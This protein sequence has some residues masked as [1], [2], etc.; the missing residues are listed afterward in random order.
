ML[1]ALKTLT[2]ANLFRRKPSTSLALVPVKKKVDP[3]DSTFYIRHTLTSWAAQVAYYPI[4][5]AE[6][7]KMDRLVRKLNRELWWRRYEP[8]YYADDINI[9]DI[10]LKHADVSPVV[11]LCLGLDP[12]ALT[13]EKQQL[14]YLFAV[15]Q[16]G[17]LRPIGDDGNFTADPISQ[18]ELQA[19]LAEVPLLIK[20]LRSDASDK[21][22]HTQLEQLLFLSG[23]V[24]LKR[25]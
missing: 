9:V 7:K 5:K 25:C 16:T 10:L 3:S 17:H 15:G 18:L 22:A 1:N 11:E 19:R 12:E 21:Y 8:G 14:L 4:L 24:A 23:M 13:L 2:P 20:R 6:S